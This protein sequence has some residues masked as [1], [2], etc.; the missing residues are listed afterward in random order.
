MVY[1]ASSMIAYERYKDSFAFLKMQLI[2]CFIGIVGMVVTAHISYRYFQRFAIPLLGFAALLLLL[3]YSPLGSGVGGFKRWIRIGGFQFQPV[4]FAKLMLIIYVA[5]F[6]SNNGEKIRRMRYILLS[7]VVLSIFFFLIYFQ[8]DFGTAVLISI[9]VFLM[10]FVG[11]ARISQIVIFGLIACFFLYS[12]VVHN[13][14]RLQRLEGFFNSTSDISGK[15]YQLWQ[16]QNTLATGGIA[17]VGIGNSIY[18]LFY[19][20]FPHTDFIFAVLGEEL[21]FIGAIG[22]IALFMA[23]VW[24]GGY[25][26]LYVSNTFGSMTAMGISTLLGLQAIVNLAVVVG[27]APVTG[28]TLPFISYGGTS[29]MMSLISIGILLNIS[30]EVEEG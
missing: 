12:A 4:E 16:S 13:P 9:V 21:G 27:L 6:L 18:K 30:R 26:S 17:G 25:I 20:P 24:R 28:L 7:V 5:R 11:G 29:L 14:Y 2:A 3:V 8:P 19:L 15:N 22:I 10:L 23:L 1:S